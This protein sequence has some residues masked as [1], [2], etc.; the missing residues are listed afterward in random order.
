MADLLDPLRVELLVLLQD[1][2]TDL[3]VEP[4]AREGHDL[5]DIDAS[6]W[7]LVNKP[8]NPL[9]SCDQNAGRRVRKTHRHWFPLIDP[10]TEHFLLAH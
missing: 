9:L 10:L 8:S 7:G 1:L 2:V 6:N 4:G 5:T 3:V